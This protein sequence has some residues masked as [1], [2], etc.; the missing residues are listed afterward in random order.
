MVEFSSRKEALD[1]VNSAA[2]SQVVVDAVKLKV[3]VFPED[4]D[5]FGRHYTREN[6]IN[7]VSKTERTYP[8]V[9]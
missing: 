5:V 3:D 8:A 1:L 4:A 9:I 6:L 2:D 7:Y